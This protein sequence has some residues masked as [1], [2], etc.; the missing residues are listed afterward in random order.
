[1]F[2][3]LQKTGIFPHSG[4]VLG[5]VH[6]RELTGIL[7][8]YV[9]VTGT[10]TCLNRRRSSVVCMTSLAMPVQFRI[11][12]LLLLLLLLML[13]LAIA[14]AISMSDGMSNDW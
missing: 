13:L 9:M 11:V 12:L 10:I 14:I 8:R 3:G 4:V 5:V 1:M 6:D 2:H 7:H